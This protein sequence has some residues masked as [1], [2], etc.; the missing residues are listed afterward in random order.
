MTDPPILQMAKEADALKEWAW[1]EQADLWDDL[2]KAIMYSANGVWSIQSADVAYRI[3]KV[4]RIVGPT[5]WEAVPWRLFAGGV[6][7]ALLDVAEVPVPELTMEQW[8]EFDELMK[9][10]GGIHV[11]L[12]LRFTMTRLELKSDLKEYLK[13]G[14]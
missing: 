5:P 6:Y 1:K 14:K 9:D 10:H 13:D 4:A 7:R 8:A 11:E 3:L 12:E 2:D